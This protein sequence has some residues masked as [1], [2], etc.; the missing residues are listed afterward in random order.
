MERICKRF[1]NLWLL[2]ASRDNF[3]VF[4]CEE[5]LQCQ[6][7]FL[8][9]L[10]GLELNGT[11]ADNLPFKLLIILRLFNNNFNNSSK[12][13]KNNEMEIEKVENLCR[14]HVMKDCEFCFKYATTSQPFVDAASGTLCSVP[15]PAVTLWTVTVSLLKSLVIVKQSGCE[16]S[17]LLACD[18]EFDIVAMFI[19]L[20]RLAVVESRQFS[21]EEIQESF[22][23]NV[24]NSFASLLS[25]VDADRLK[26]VASAV[27]ETS[28]S[29]EEAF[30]QQDLIR[31]RQ[32]ERTILQIVQYTSEP[33]TTTVST[34]VQ[35]QQ[36]S[37][38][39]SDKCSTTMDQDGDDAFI[40]TEMRRHCLKSKRIISSI[41]CTAFGSTDTF[42]EAMD[43]ISR[44]VSP[45]RRTISAFSMTQQ[46][47]VCGF[48]AA[49][50]PS[51]RLDSPATDRRS[52]SFAQQSQPQS[53]I[54]GQGRGYVEI[55]NA[56]DSLL[57]NTGSTLSPDRLSPH[58]DVKVFDIDTQGNVVP[59]SPTTPDA[60]DSPRRISPIR[61]TPPSPAPPVM[62]IASATTSAGPL[63]HQRRFA[64]DRSNF[65]QG[66]QPENWRDS[67]SRLDDVVA[68]N[69][70][71]QE[72][73][74]QMSSSSSAVTGRSSLAGSRAARR[75]FSA[76]E[77]QALQE[78]LSKFGKQWSLILSKYKNVFEPCRSNVDLKDKARNE[79]KRLQRARKPLGVWE[80]V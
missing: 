66:H 31:L 59:E 9:L 41:F 28:N 6:F 71:N 36:R 51:Q 75:P 52:V 3:L 26:S 68:D 12:D 39:V 7:E 47:H 32:I 16:Q 35:H 77:V 34:D 22:I 8:Q 58:S 61:P 72:N 46:Q 11:I 73:H 15:L 70:N 44:E 64:S 38:A 78:G 45:S 25:P 2:S 43:L 76:R 57:V 53:P 40:V 63:N 19:D 10:L 20:I 1:Y 42:R 23:Q 56:Y 13:D 74:E 24:I 17:K 60:N 80:I 33:Q 67:G 54:G 48:N 62:R 55:M 50:V 79:K 30:T 27:F 4:S 21:H 37:I 65:N 29:L 49:I 69:N 18:E 14:F 5:F